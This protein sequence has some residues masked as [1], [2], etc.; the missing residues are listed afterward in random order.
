MPGP[1]SWP[2]VSPLSGRETEI[3]RLTTEAAEGHCLSLVGMSNIGKSFV[4]RTLCKAADARA[5]GATFV[6]VDC[7]RMVEFTEQG[8]YELV[9]RCLKAA[10][11]ADAESSP[12]GAELERC[13]ADVIAPASPFLA[14]LSFS[15]GLAAASQGAAGRIVLVLDEF[16]EVMQGMDDRV[17][18]NLR[19]L[20]DT[21]PDELGYITASRRRLATLR[22]ARG[23]SEF[24]ELF[25]QGTCFLAPLDCEATAALVGRC[26]HDDNLALTPDDAPFIYEESGGHP[27]LAISAAHALSALRRDAQALG[28]PLSEERMREHLD[29]DP[30]CQGECAKLWQDMDQDERHALLHTEGQDSAARQSAWQRLEERHLVRRG[31][32]GPVVFSR[33]LATYVRRQR[34]VRRAETRGVRVDVEAGDVWVDGR[35]IPAL[36]DLE[37]RLLLLLYGHLDKIV[38]KYAVVQ[39]VWGQDYIDEVDDARIEKL[40]SRLRQKIEPDPSQPQYLQTIRGRGYRLASG[41]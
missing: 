2:P 7:N 36:T 3:R 17:L 39:A 29:S 33:L 10:V 15:S 4:L 19:A 41:Q 5:T 13:Y 23:S 31:E 35:L 16:D 34:I 14:H 20:R 37:Y 9:L 24:A 26:V 11:A 28:R 12:L 25:D 1:A 32:R 18:L 30:A 38:D 8:F 40:V 6:Y 27:A 21:A 22:R